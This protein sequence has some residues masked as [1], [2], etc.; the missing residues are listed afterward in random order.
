M[1]CSSDIKCGE[2]V[3]LCGGPT[4]FEGAAIGQVFTGEVQM[5]CP[6]A[7]RQ[8]TVPQQPES[9]PKEAGRPLSTALIALAIWQ[10]LHAPQ[11]VD[12]ALGSSVVHALMFFAAGV[13]TRYFKSHTLRRLTRV[14][15]R[16]RSNQ[17]H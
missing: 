10:A 16:R 14:F 1:G 12:G 5:Q 15:V 4:V 6:F 7:A 9:A 3:F 17:T 2:A 11:S 8:S 13:L